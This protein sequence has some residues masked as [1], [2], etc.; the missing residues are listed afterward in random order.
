MDSLQQAVAAVRGFNRVYT[1]HFQLLDQRHLGSEFSLGEV[2]VLYELAHREGLSAAE[3]ARGLDLDPGHLSRML[4]GLRRR[5]LVK[6]ERSAQDRRASVLDLTPAGRRAFGRLDRKA[7]TLVSELLR[8]F[9]DGDRQT[10]VQTLSGVRRLLEPRQG[11]S[12]TVVLRNHRIGDLGWN[13]ERHGVV[14][15]GEYGW[16][17]AFEALVAQVIAEFAQKHDP[18]REACWVAELDGQRVGTVMLV[19]HPER[20]GVAKLRLLLVEPEARGL[21]IGRALVEACTDFARAAGYERVTLWT[22]SVLDAARA[23]YARTGYVK[24]SEAPNELFGKGLI[25]ETWELEL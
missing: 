18:T 19:G 11:G 12:P 20:P 24:V 9:P 17:A 22:Q 5:G 15:A 10:L 1:R 4:S 2:R 14:Y 16:G 21:G 8:G 7:E 3:L 23:I 13:L 6:R 25:A